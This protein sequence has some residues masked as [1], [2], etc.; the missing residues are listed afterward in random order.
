MSSSE[1]PIGVM[2]EPDVTQ[3]AVFRG[4]LSRP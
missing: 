1:F 4:S 3:R 2:D